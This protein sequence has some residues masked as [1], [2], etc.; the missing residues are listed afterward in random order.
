MEPVFDLVL[1]RDP[2]YMTSGKYTAGSII[3]VARQMGTNRQRVHRW[4][5]L[6]VGAYE[7][8]AIAV[9]LELHPVVIWPDWFE[10]APTEGEAASSESEIRVIELRST[11]I[12]Y[13]AI[14]QLLTEEGLLHP[15][16][17]DGLGTNWLSETR[18]ERRH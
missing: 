8:D 12:T 5:L 16:V 7:A 17:Q 14:A 10:H 11:G 13:R 3:V 15:R 4:N 9:R 18:V 2:N 1:V 6:G